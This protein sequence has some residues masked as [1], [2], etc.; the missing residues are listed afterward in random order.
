LERFFNEDFAKKR[1]NEAKKRSFQTLKP[2]ISA[3][4]KR[5]K[6]KG[7]ILTDTDPGDPSSSAQEWRE[8][9]QPPRTETSDAVPLPQEE[10]SD[11]PD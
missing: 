7:L 4:L 6:A 1:R 11:R 9:V 8:A 3:Y 2:A 5:Q 10:K